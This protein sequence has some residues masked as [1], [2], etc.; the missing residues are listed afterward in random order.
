MSDTKT[1]GKEGECVRD[2]C[3][4]Y[5]RELCHRRIL[6]DGFSEFLFM[7][8]KDIEA[9]MSNEGRQTCSRDRRVCSVR[10]EAWLVFC[11]TSLV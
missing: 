11:S 6:V 4:V 8:S 1:K 7:G 5:G 2:I 9:S 10:T 3:I